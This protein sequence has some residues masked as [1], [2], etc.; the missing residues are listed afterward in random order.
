MYKKF[1]RTSVL[2]LLLLSQV[3]VSGL[4][5]AADVALDDISPTGGPT[6][7]RMQIN[8][9]PIVAAAEDEETVACLKRPLRVRVGSP[10]HCVACVAWCPVFFP[11]WWL[12]TC[13]KP[14]PQE[15]CC[16]RSCSQYSYLAQS[17]G[18]CTPDSVCACGRGWVWGDCCC[19]SS[20]CVMKCCREVSP[21]V[22]SVFTTIV[23]A[24]FCC[25]GPVY[26][27]RDYTICN[28]TPIQW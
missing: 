8:N 11:C 2:A 13:R 7:Q 3:V 23:T 28:P 20:P 5:K 27:E 18:G 1:L 15:S 21:P 6:T 14:T 16:G 22:C 24:G 4:A 12:M 25:C 26:E 10:I 9:D 17:T 19:T